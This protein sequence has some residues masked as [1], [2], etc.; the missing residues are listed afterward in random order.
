MLRH[1]LLVLAF[2]V[3]ITGSVTASLRAQREPANPLARVEAWECTFRTYGVGQWAGE[4]LT[5][6]TGSDDLTF[7]VED[8]DLRRGA[9]RVVAAATIE[10]TARLTPT[11]LNLI[12]QTPGGNFILT[13]IFASTVAT[14]TYHAAHARHL[15]DPDT[16]PS[17]SQ[18]HGTCEAAD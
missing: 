10:V 8:I 16:P 6:L 14:D 5:V 4:E 17:A 13:T 15:G 2:V 3:G 11:G 9:A 7:R 1:V 12:E 18:F